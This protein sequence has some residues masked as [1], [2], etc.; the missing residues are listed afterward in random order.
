MRGDTTSLHPTR[1]HRDFSP[2]YAARL[3]QQRLTAC[4][5]LADR[6]GLDDVI[7][8]LLKVKLLAVRLTHPREAR[9]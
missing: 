1:D 4:V 2:A 6:A 8:E 9:S 5:E 7:D 3:L